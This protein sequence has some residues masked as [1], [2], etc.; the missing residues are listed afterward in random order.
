M[1]VLAGI[2][3]GCVAGGVASYLLPNDIIDGF[4]T[5]CIGVGVG[6]M[7]GSHVG[8]SIGTLYTR[9]AIAARSSYHSVRVQ[10]STLFPVPGH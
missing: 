6:I 2:A 10:D 5:L 7:G 9:D 8:S 3:F 4:Y 1:G